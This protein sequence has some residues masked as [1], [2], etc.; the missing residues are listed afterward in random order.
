MLKYLNKSK[1][2][3]GECSRPSRH[4]IH[5]LFLVQ[6]DEKIDTDTLHASGRRADYKGFLEGTGYSR[7]H[8]PG[9]L[10]QSS[11][12]TEEGRTYSTELSCARQC[13]PRHAR[14][15]HFHSSNES[16][17]KVLC[18]DM[19]TPEWTECQQTAGPPPQCKI[20]S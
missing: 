7:V 13:V 18:V 1:K 4:M 2:Y 9:S 19:Q 3:F 11:E 10:A 12:P 5:F 15:L 17:F 14:I 16:T 20:N 8:K 6:W